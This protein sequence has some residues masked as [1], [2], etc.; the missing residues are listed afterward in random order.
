[1]VTV[2]YNDYFPLIDEELVFLPGD[3]EQCVNVSLVDDDSYEPVEFFRIIGTSDNQNGVV[4]VGN[5]TIEIVDNDSKMNKSNSPAIIT[6]HSFSLDIEI[7]LS[8]AN[9]SEG[10]PFATVRV[11]ISSGKLETVIDLL[12]STEDVSARG[13]NTGILSIDITDCFMTYSVQQVGKII[14]QLAMCLSC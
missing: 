3:M 2:D 14:L 8:G 13:T 9:V 5:V 12:V 6:S 7:N 11:E 1:M 4:V 10:D